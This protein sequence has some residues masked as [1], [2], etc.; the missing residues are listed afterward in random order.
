MGEKFASGVA[1]RGGAHGDEDPGRLCAHARPIRAQGRP[2]RRAAACESRFNRW[3]MALT[4]LGSVAA[5]P[6]APKTSLARERN[7]EG[8]PHN[9]GGTPRKGRDG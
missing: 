7:D 5:L 2:R 1:A 4:H 6:E 9:L 3:R 8:A